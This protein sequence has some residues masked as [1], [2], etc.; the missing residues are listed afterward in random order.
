MFGAS[1]NFSICK[2]YV[3]PIMLLLCASG[4]CTTAVFVITPERI[5]AGIDRMANEPAANGTLVN[6]GTRRK[7]ALLKGRFIVVCVG[8]EAMRGGPS[9]TQQVVLYSFPNWVREIE[10]QIKPNTSVATLAAV[11]ERESSRTFRDFVPIESMMRTGALKHI[12]AMDKFLVQ[13]VV[14]GF[15]NRVITLIEVNYELDWQNNLLIGPKP[16]VHLPYDGI[17]TALYLCGQYGAIETDKLRDRN[18][19]AHKRMDALAPIAFNKILGSV[20]T[21]Q[22][23][24]VYAVR[25]LITIEGEVDPSEIGS[26]STVVIL[27]VI[28]N[29][30]VTEYQNSLPHPDANAGKKSNSH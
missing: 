1:K 2:S 11:V 10:S 29:G 7:I 23:E 8:L 4:F 9:P 13:F 6:V 22:T 16:I 28:A 12:K 19:Y 14:A 17:T 3:L 5:V 27:P 15:D 25:A 26:G 21:S 24:A 18:S 30:T 20:P